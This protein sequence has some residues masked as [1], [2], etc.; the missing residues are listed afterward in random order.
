[1]KAEDNAAAFYSAGD[2]RQIGDKVQI[3]LGTNRVWLADNW[4][5]T[6]PR[7]TRWYTLPSST[8]PY[9]DYGTDVKQD[10]FKGGVGQVIACRWASDNRLVVLCHRAVLLF[11]RDDDENWE[12]KVLSYHEEKCGD[13]D[14][15]DI[16]TGPSEWVPPVGSWTDLA[17]YDN[18]GNSRFYVA[19]TSHL[20]FDDN[21]L[22]EFDRMD[23]LWWYDGAGRYHHTGLR[24]HNSP[25][26]DV[27]TEAPAL[28][29]TVD[30]DDKNIVYVGTAIGV[31]RGVLTFTG[32]T[33]Q[34]KWRPFSNGLPETAVHDLSFFNHSGLKLLR[35]ALGSRGI[36]ELDVS[37]SPRP[38]RRTYLR[39]HKFDTRRTA[40]TSLI[41]PQSKD[42]DDVLF[43]WYVSPDV[44]IRPAQGAPVPRSPE[45]SL[46]RW[47]SQPTPF[48]TH[49]LWAF[50]TAFRTLQPL[51]RP[52][53]RWTDQFESLLKAQFGQGTAEINETIWNTVVT[54]GT[55]FT[56]P[57]G[58]NDPT[59]A[60]LYEMVVE[61]AFNGTSI[62]ER[63]VLD[64][65][66][67]HV[68]VLVHH[69]DSR[70]VPASQVRVTLLRR[71]L[72]GPEETWGSVAIST[73]WKVSVQQLLSGDPL[74]PG[75]SLDDGWSTANTPRVLSPRGAVDART[76]RAVTF[77]L[78][79]TAITG[80][81]TR[82]VLLAIVHS[83]ADPVSV[84]SLA[85]STLEELVTF[86]HH[87]AARII[88]V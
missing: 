50:Q 71:L 3:A 1:L 34:W 15:D 62:S 75:W 16:P 4:D 25:P 69:R 65:R 22:E 55:V 67:Y 86:S 8:D 19:T 6:G 72:T 37:P 28:A 5:P 12:R 49:A 31:W 77:D 41:N 79:F 20:K 73:A 7:A 35:G 88:A 43:K 29:V 83:S 36:W 56:P 32:N 61:Q 54:A 53:G 47:N 57:W 24:N 70:P 33:P 85:G 38:V 17:I 2:I 18:E 39:V 52:N 87:V 48:D 30:P 45:G 60:D 9:E 84:A 66:A 14:N 51:C 74:P 82:D 42:S 58:D 13:L 26:D 81:R 21:S 23:T 78:N 44:R 63:P 27:G 11:D 46:L 40:L 80:P 59:E 10:T 68:D 64:R 76:P